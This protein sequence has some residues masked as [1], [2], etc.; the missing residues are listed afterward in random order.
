MN[1][2]M[3]EHAAKW[4]KDCHNRGLTMLEAHAWLNSEDCLQYEYV[5]WVVYIAL[6]QKTSKDLTRQQKTSFAFSDHFE[7]KD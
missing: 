4:I 1:R 5:F 7:T 6:K 3:E 2:M